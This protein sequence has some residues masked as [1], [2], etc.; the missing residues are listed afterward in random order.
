MSRREL[1]NRQT[2]LKLLNYSNAIVI[3][4]G[5]IGNWVA[6]DLALSG[7]VEDLY[8]IDPDTVE[9]SNLNRT[10][11]DYTDIGCYKVDSVCKQIQI[12][13]PEQNVYSMKCYMNDG[14]AKQFIAKLF[15]N[16]NTYYHSETVVVDCR[17]DIY[18]D[19]Y[20]LNCKLYKVG[21]DGADIT[22][23]GNP[24]LTEV[25]GQRGGSYSVTPS[26]VGSSQMAAILVVNDILYPKICQM[27]QKNETSEST[28]D[29]IDSES[30]K[31][32]F[33]Y[34]N[35]RPCF[36]FDEFGRLNDSINLNVC[37]ILG[38]FVEDGHTYIKPN[39][40]W[41]NLPNIV[42]EENEQESEE[43]ETTNG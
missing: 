16:D 32:D 21:Y 7:C 28:I 38:K 9:E 39:P 33:P 30:K 20:Q 19:C 29:R 6:L 3:G 13:R 43:K 18:D 1:Y 40:D 2:S 5:G 25:Y 42:K 17:D 35:S 4:C 14:L 37:D 24:R 23:D 31:E 15:N 11:F 41:S 27:V 8:I 34:I 22:I 10:L 12:R 36:E 26:Y